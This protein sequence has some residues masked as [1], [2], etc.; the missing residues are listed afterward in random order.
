MVLRRAES[1]DY[2]EIAELCTEFFDEH[3][4][5]EKDVKDILGY[6]EIA[7][8]EHECFISKDE[9]KLLASVFLVKLGESSDGS[10]TRWRLRHFAW[11]DEKAAAEL[12]L[13][14]EKHIRT[15]SRTAKIEV[16]LAETEKHK[17][18]YEACSFSQEGIL[19]NHFRWGESCFVFGKSLE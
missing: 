11:R 18:L 15:L 16:R 13:A 17:A 2:E 10:H 19:D 9:H 12:L 5:F 7:A 6:L 4:I 14:V 1:Q 8:N 3:D